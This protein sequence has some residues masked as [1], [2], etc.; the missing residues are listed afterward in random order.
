MS[1]VAMDPHIFFQPKSSSSS[2]LANALATQ[3][4]TNSAHSLNSKTVGTVS[5][6]NIAYYLGVKVSE[7]MLGRTQT[8]KHFCQTNGKMSL[9]GYF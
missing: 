4:S 5:R 3:G 6:I 1:T 9:D 8:L 2:L 7:Q